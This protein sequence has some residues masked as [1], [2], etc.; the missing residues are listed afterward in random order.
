VAQAPGASEYPVTDFGTLSGNSRISDV[1]LAPGARVS[2]F[3]EP[4]PHLPPEA[5]S[6]FF[7]K[8]TKNHPKSPTP[9]CNLLC[10]LAQGGWLLGERTDTHHSSC[11]WG[12]RWSVGESR[13]Y[14]E[15]SEENERQEYGAEAEC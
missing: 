8:K 3:P 7:L 13:G 6:Q 4:F 2:P 14:E 10:K 12:L 11:C 9:A 1:S 15:K 5:C